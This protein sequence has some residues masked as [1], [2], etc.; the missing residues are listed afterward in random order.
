MSQQGDN[1]A[2][3]DHVDHSRQAPRQGPSED[4]LEIKIVG[5]E[6]TEDPIT[7]D[8]DARD[9]SRQSSGQPVQGEVRFDESF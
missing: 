7:G 3:F 5:P 9:H 1:T 2:P 4:G 8:G 6:R